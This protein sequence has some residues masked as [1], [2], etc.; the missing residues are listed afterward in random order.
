MLA[1]HQVDCQIELATNDLWTKGRTT[2]KQGVTLAKRGDWPG[3][4]EKWEQ[5]LEQNP[6]N[7]AALFNLAIAHAHSQNYCEA[8]DYGMRA[9]RIEH[10]DCYAKGLEKIRELRAS[11]E[12]VETQRV[13]SAHDE[14]ETTW[15]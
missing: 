9:V 7:H 4:A 12:R 13:A 10:C 8:E 5:A 1:P 6:E 3:A 15:R 2:V 11:Y 14:T